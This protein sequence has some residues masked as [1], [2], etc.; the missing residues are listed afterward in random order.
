MKKSLTQK[1]K[2]KVQDDD[3]EDYET[4]KTKGIDELFIQQTQLSHND[5]KKIDKLMQNYEDQ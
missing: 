3:D 1:Q 5:Q 2:N 4:E